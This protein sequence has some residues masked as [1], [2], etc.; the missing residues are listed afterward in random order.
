MKIFIAKTAGF[1]MGV[2]RAVEM[3]LDAPSKHEEPISTYGPLIHN[4]QVLELLE[5]K[6]IHTIDQIPENGKGTVLV[7]AHGV[8]PQAKIDLKNAGCNVIDATCPRVIKVQTIIRK[9]AQ[10]GY[11]VIILG[12]RGHP[13]VVGLSGYA[14]ENG[15]VVGTLAELEQLPRFEQ[16]IVVAQTTLNTVF[17]QDVKQWFGH[18]HPRYKIYDTIC[19]STH[20]RQDEV[21]RLAQSVDA[22]VVVGGRNSGNTQRLAEIGKQSGKP[23]YHIESEAELKDLPLANVG[24]VA[25]TAGA[26]TPNW[27]INRVFRTLEKIPLKKGLTWRWAVFTAQR[28]LLLTNIYL[29]LGAASLCFTS[30]KLLDVHPYRPYMLI[31]MAYVFSMHILNNFIGTKAD[32]YNDPG[33]A[34]FY[35]KYNKILVVLAVVAGGYGLTTAATIGAKPFSVLFLMSMLGLSYTLKLIPKKPAARNY[36]RIRDIPG[37]KTILIALAWG[38]AATVLPAL[39]ALGKFHLNALITFLW[40][41]GLVFVRTA[42]FDILDM[43]G[44][45]ILGRNTIPLVFGQK[46]T[47]RFLKITLAVMMVLLIIA[48]AFGIVPNLTVALT[49]CPMFLWLIIA[50]FEN[51]L[52]FPG[53]RLEFLV[54]S[55]FILAGVITLVYSAFTG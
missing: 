14:G 16:A 5:E 11:A 32:R 37:S 50:A 44:D 27:V 55:Q 40:V 21:K 51:G 33:R 9:H 28:G 22:I 42:F 6:E 3:V 35:D 15:H 41:S 18:K 1:C 39:S 25:I 48:A 8:P 7:R 46:K 43:Q 38:V 31:A 26:S 34:Y 10:K 53:F 19:D 13:E 47:L 20:R 17:F 36:R 12:D 2:R 54:E 24:R 30:A 45:R 29:A 49:V 52:I 23:T 4:P